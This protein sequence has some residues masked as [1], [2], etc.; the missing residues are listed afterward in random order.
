MRLEYAEWLAGHFVKRIAPFLKRV[1]IAGSIRRRREF[2]GDIEVVAIPYMNT[3][4]FSDDSTPLMDPLHIELSKL[5]TI[6]RGGDRYI[7]IHLT[8]PDQYADIFLVWPPAQWGSIFAIRTG[9]HDLSQYVVTRMRDLGYFH[10]NG[11][12]HRIDSGEVVPTPTE[13]D[14]FSLAGLKCPEPQNRDHF[15]KTLMGT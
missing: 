3:D 15:A 5:G 11:H 9:P 14:F 12:A 2:V 6:V 8:K 7:R 13:E 10:Q 1:E 4:L